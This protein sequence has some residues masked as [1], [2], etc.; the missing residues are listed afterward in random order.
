MVLHILTFLGFSSIGSDGFVHQRNTVGMK[1][2]VA[3]STSM[4][5]AIP[6]VSVSTVGP[7]VFALMLCFFDGR[8]IIRRSS[9]VLRRCRR[10][11]LPREGKWVGTLNS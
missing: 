5:G 2:D 11:V 1:F 6:D 9:N 7:A 8:D 10:I 3:L 4:D